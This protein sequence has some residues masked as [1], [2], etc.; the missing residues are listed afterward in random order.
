MEVV[1]LYQLPGTQGEEKMCQEKHLVL[2]SLHFINSSP[3]LGNS[4]ASF[5]SPSLLTSPHFFLLFPP[6]LLLKG[7]CGFPFGGGEGQ[8]QNGERREKKTFLF[9]GKKGIFSKREASREDSSML[10]F[11][12]LFNS[13]AY[14]CLFI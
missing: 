8:V 2:L 6:L 1:P 12:E 9:F 3:H 4:P 13:N 7:F 11:L 5:F 14:F 10:S